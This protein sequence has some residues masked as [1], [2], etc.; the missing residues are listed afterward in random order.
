MRNENAK[1]KALI[2]YLKTFQPG[3]I[4]FS[5][6]V[7][8]TLLLYLAKEAWEKTPTAVI[9]RSP[10]LTGKERERIK[11]LVELLRVRHYWLN[12]KE[13]LEPEFKNNTPRRCY[14]CK[15][16]R[17]KLARRFLQQKG[18]QYLL[19]GTNADDLK[20]HRPGITAGR[21]GKVVSPFADQNWTKKEIRSL[22]RRWG[23]PT[24]DQPSSPCLA[25][26][27]AYGQRVTRPLL[28]KLERGEEILA[29][30]GFDQCRLRV[31]GKI[32]RIEIPE[33]GFPL[34]IAPNRRKVLLNRLSA[35]GFPYLTLDLK[36][37]RSGSMDELLK[38][39]RKGATV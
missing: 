4:A 28:S 35:L 1:T 16:H 7:D 33:K 20:V 3:V 23:L 5:G 30:S 31:H 25:T 26:R 14:F 12:S 34:I 27:V 37:F 11:S 8:S 36:G 17:I 32:T 22:S 2:R 15:K 21:E 24:W 6:G 19:D 9:F 10:L 29:Q 18:L 13:Y 38:N 39:P